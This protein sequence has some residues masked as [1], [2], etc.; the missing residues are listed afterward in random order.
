MR[1][2]NRMLTSSPE[3]WFRYLPVRNP[4]WLRAR[5]C[6]CFDREGHLG[7]LQGWAWVVAALFLV[8]VA[9][10]E[11]LHSDRIFRSPEI[12][13]A[14]LPITYVTLG[15]FVTIVASTSVVGDR[16]RGFLDIVLTTPLTSREIVDGTFLSVWTH[17]KRLSWLPLALA[18]LFWFTGAGK[19]TGLAISLALVGA[20]MAALV[21]VGIACSVSARS[22][23]GTLVP[24]FLFLLVPN[25]GIA[26]LIPIFMRY[27]PF[28]LCFLCVTGLLIASAWVRRKLTPASVGCYLYFAFQSLV[29]AATIL[30]A[31]RDSPDGSELVTASMP[32]VLSFTVLSP[33]R[34]PPLDNLPFAEW[35]RPCFLLGVML[36]C[37]WARMWLITHYDALAGRA[38][39][40]RR[41]P[42]SLAGAIAAL[43]HFF[44]W[45]IPEALR[46]RWRPRVKSGSQ[47]MESALSDTV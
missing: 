29:T 37:V 40:H 19:F 43:V 35:L 7:R 9:I 6:H 20:Y 44:Y 34:T 41:R 24:T 33:R 23:T 47:E 12:V 4:L 31:W 39:M 8:L 27:A 11:Y 5:Q 13:L 10:G 17:V 36:F 38:S 2:R 32:T 46:P 18:G 45:H 30:I 26:F 42:G 15:I 21:L 25:L 1:S 14:F 28:A 3:R 16:R 22:L